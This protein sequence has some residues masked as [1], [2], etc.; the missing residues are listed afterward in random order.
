MNKRTTALRDSLNEVA[1]RASVS[2]ITSPDLE[3]ELTSK[4]VHYGDLEK[5]IGEVK[6][7]I[8][9]SI[10]LQDESQGSLR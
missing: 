4:Y 8:R 7:H 6:N 2:L 3:F 5:E 10:A 9:D 1:A